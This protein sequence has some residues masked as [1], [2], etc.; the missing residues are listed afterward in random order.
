MG[1]DFQEV[2]NK[3]QGL[4][5]SILDL[6]EFSREPLVLAD[7]GASGRIHEK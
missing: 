7:I 2:Q 5:N 6:E 3:R 1:I 4:I